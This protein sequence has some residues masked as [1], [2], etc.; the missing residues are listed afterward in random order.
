MTIKIARV[1][2]TTEIYQGLQAT[3]VALQTGGVPWV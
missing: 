3:R 1:A 2:F